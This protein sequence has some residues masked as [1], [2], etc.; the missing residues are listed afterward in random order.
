MFTIV[1]RVD[2]PEETR[3][4]I[5]IADTYGLEYTLAPHQIYLFISTKELLAQVAL[6]LKDDKP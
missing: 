2:S 5:A 3:H 6:A 4:I 1:I